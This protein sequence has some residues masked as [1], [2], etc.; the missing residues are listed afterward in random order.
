MQAGFAVVRTVF[1]GCPHGMGG[2]CST[3]PGFAGYHDRLP[4]LK[5]KFPALRVWCPDCNQTDQIRH[6]SWFSVLVRYAG[7]PLIPLH[8]LCRASCHNCLALCLWIPVHRFY[9]RWD[10]SVLILTMFY[11]RFLGTGLMWDPF[12]WPPLRMLLI[13]RYQLQKKIQHT[14]GPQTPNTNYPITPNT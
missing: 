4:G 6:H 11:T 14:P 9:R 8:L 1:S 7:P 13:R 2:R 10:L 12:D 3:S 5:E